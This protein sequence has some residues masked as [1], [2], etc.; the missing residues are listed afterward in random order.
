MG[1]SVGCCGE[2]ESMKINQLK[3]RKKWLETNQPETSGAETQ[4]Y[5]L[6]TPLA[7]DNHETDS[8][9]RSDRNSDDSYLEMLDAKN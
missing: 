3:E 8:W 5:E 7:T 9:A 6:Q 1:N 4:R 2:D